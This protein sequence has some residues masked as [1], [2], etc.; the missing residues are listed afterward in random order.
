M[1]EAMKLIPWNSASSPRTSQTDAL[2]RNIENLFDSFFGSSR[3]FARV[4]DWT[5]SLDVKETRDELV[6]TADLP[7]IKKE[8]IVLKVEQGVLSISGERKSEQSKDGEGWHRVERSYGSFLR[9]VA[10][11][12]G[13]DEN[14]VRAE[15]KDGVLK[16]QVA[17]SEA[18]KPRSI[19]ID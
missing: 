5:P 19:T 1:E 2:D 8:D 4:A 17:K 16:V 6:I 18:A 9:S 12:Q 3:A 7:G 14:K 11:P 15:Y 13:V 10:L